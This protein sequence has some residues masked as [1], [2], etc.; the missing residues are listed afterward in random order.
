M[1]K[2]FRLPEPFNTAFNM[3]DSIDYRVNPNS[4]RTDH[5]VVR[6]LGYDIK[7]ASDC[8]FYASE[9]P[10][11][12]LSSYG[13]WGTFYNSRADDSEKELF[14]RM[15]REEVIK[16]WRITAW[17]NVNGSIERFEYAGYWS[18]YDKELNSLVEVGS[19]YKSLN[20]NTI[21]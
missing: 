18:V 5:N 20:K 6:E 9:L 1:E 13:D 7:M 19:P 15:C 10:H 8:S 14:L 3:G 16:P 2:D 21:K 11:F 17:R 4:G 12:S